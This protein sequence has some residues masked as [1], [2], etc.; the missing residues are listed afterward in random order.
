[1]T[2]IAGPWLEPQRPMRGRD[3]HG[4]SRLICM[5]WYRIKAVWPPV[6][7]RLICIPPHRIVARR[8]FYLSPYRATPH[9][10]NILL[11]FR[12]VW[13]L[14]PPSPA[15]EVRR[16]MQ[17]KADLMSLSSDLTFR[18]SIGIWLIFTETGCEFTQWDRRRIR[19]ENGSAT[20]RG[21]HK[22]FCFVLFRFSN[23]EH[24]LKIHLETFITPC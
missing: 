22:S 7:P 20:H 9:L 2:V 21:R 10:H 11:A 12:V 4:Q 15:S 1:M 17:V 5:P 13:R 14:D 23:W 24:L 18:N 3:A 8:P 19:N 16:R 6:C